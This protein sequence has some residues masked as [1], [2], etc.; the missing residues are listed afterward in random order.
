M[1][2]IP[3]RS[4]MA[5]ARPCYSGRVYGQKPV[6]DLIV[7]LVL[8]SLRAMSFLLASLPGV[9]ASFLSAF[10]FGRFP[11]QS[12][13]WWGCFDLAHPFETVIAAFAVK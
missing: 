9:P 3:G 1:M 10:F 4:I 5:P 12:S 7:L 13:A 11:G 2:F 6:L 8:V